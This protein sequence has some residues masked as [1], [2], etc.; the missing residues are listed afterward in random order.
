M[1]CDSDLMGEAFSSFLSTFSLL[2]RIHHR[3]ST[4]NLLPKI[5]TPSSSNTIHY[6]MRIVYIASILASASAFAPQ[7][8]GLSRQG[9]ATE[10][11]IQD[12]FDRIFPSKQDVVEEEEEEVVAVAAKPKKKSSDAM[13]KADKWISDIFNNFEPIHGHGSGH[14]ELQDIQQNQEN[15]LEEQTLETRS[16]TLSTTGL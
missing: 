1:G 6:T 13:K 4:H 3:F 10:A 9:V 11:S 14:T 15:V 5:S 2:F 7:N 12:Y 8:A 16:T